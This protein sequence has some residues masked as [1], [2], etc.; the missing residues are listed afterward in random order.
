MTSQAIPGAAVEAASRVYYG[1]A[2][3]EW[4]DA[5]PEYREAE[6]ATFRAIL[7]AA[8]PYMLAQA[9]EAAIQA[10]DD[11]GCLMYHQAKG[12]RAANPYRTDA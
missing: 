4:E 11:E 9:W 12:L 3:S 6:L 8:A 5:T 7:A 10:A 1:S 2:I